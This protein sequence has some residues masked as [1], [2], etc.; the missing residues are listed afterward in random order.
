MPFLNY[1]SPAS[2]APE[3]M[4]N[5]ESEEL[6][7]RAG[8]E[9][10]LQTPDKS[11]GR[12]FC[13]IGEKGVG[14]SILTRKV[15][16]GLREVHAATTLFLIVDCRR[17][18]DQHGVYGEVARQA[19]SQLAFRQD[20][21][22]AL[23]A[24]AHVLATIAGF[25]AVE[26]RELHEHLVQHQ[27][28]S[29]LQ[30]GRL[31]RYLGATFNISL[32]LSRKSR[33]TLEGKVRFDGH[34][35]REAVVD[36]FQDVREHAGIDVVLYLDNIDELDHDAIRSEEGRLRVRKETD[37]LLGLAHAPI[38]LILN[39]RTYF[40]SI[41][42]REVDNPR[43][44]RRMAPA[45]HIALVQR[46]LSHEAGDVQAELRGEAAMSGLRQLATVAP[47]PLALLEWFRYLCERDLHGSEDF[48]VGLRGMLDDYFA[49]LPIKVIERVAALFEDPDEPAPRSRI[50][51][52]CNENEAVLD[53]LL[54]QQVVLP[55]DFWHPHEFTLAPELHFLLE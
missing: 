22:R 1:L 18:R 54:L 37:G 29:N 24:N 32:G 47:T 49:S 23:V 45:D 46:R 20:V 19:V 9:S 28:A 42:T 34:R 51:A 21:D 50:L 25:D 44:L 38:G 39:M 15:I 10:Y 53:Q 43:V 7:L 27:M 35:L 14:K 33:E 2:V 6:W 48:L 55:Q 40:A 8:L 13:I 12:A 17:F 30:S 36:F 3:D 41:L 4:V 16:A 52:A 31:L 26:R 5:R 11:R